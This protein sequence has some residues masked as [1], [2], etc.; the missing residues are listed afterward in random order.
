MFKSRLNCQ[1]SLPKI[2]KN[3]QMKLEIE[4][5]FS[6]RNWHLYRLFRH[7]AVAGNTK[8]CRQPR[9]LTTLYIPIIVIQCFAGQL[10]SWSSECAAVNVPIQTDSLLS[11]TITELSTSEPL[12]I[13]WTTVLQ[14]TV[15][16]K[17]G[18]DNT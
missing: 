15:L 3:T 6:I 18:Y 16:Y 1:L 13:P 5:I 9:T 17:Q 8:V 12:P 11:C 7:S 10:S 4:T 14:S 2:W